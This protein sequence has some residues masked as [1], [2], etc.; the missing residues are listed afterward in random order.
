MSDLAK[1]PEDIRDKVG[2]VRDVRG[3]GFVGHLAMLA[4]LVA[5]LAKHGGA[6]FVVAYCVTCANEPQRAN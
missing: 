1:F 2:I 5:G 6:L 3:W 4:N